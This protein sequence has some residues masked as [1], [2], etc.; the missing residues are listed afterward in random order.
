GSDNGLDV[1]GLAQGLHS[2]IV[3]HTEQD[4]FKVGPG[5]TVLGDFADAAVLHIGAE[6]LGEHHTDLRFA[7]AA[8]TFDNHHPLSLI[9]GDEAVTYKLLDGWDIFR[10]E[11]VGQEP[12]PVSG[13]GS[14]GVVS[15]R[16]PVA[17]HFRFAFLKAAVQ[18]QGTIGQ[19]DT[20]GD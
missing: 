11:E 10:I 20:V 18:V 4:V 17:D 9:A 13:L 15:D 16:Q 3:I 5:K 6:Q 19:V 14:F 12:Q 8:S 1:V 2:H 7:F